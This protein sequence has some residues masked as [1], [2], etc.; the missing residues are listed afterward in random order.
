LDGVTEGLPGPITVVKLGGSAITD[1]KVP[2]SY[3][4]RAVRELGKAMASSR[5]PIV[6]VH[7]GG[8]FGHTVARKYGLSSRRSSPS[9]EGVSETRDAMLKLDGKVCASLSA[10]GIRPYPFAPFTLLDREGEGGPSFLERLILGGMTPLTF[11]DVVHD[12]K[13]FRI[14]SGDTICV[15]LAE[16]LGAVRCVMTL[17]VDG[18]LDEKGAVI[19]AMGE[20]EAGT[21]PKGTGEGGDATGGIVLKVSEA[22]R[23]ASTGTE[24]RL[25]SGLRPEEFSK[26]L[27]GVPFHGTTVKVPHGV[28]SG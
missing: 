2:F 10:A 5:M 24:V 25:V 13:G 6:V 22:L 23:M 21:I 28:S 11:G 1:K 14:L 3:R 20:G 15:E 27:K 17:D 7:G 26:A 16:M 18:L 8:S 9:P 19:K 12:G 4:G